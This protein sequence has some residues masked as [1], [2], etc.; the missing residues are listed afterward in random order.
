[1]VTWL[2]QK[3]VLVLTT[4]I[5]CALQSSVLLSSLSLYIPHEECSF[6][7]LQEIT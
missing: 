4:F 5:A 3:G 1:M 6:G 2:H 7:E